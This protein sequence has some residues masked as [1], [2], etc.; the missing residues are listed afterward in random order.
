MTGEYAFLQH[1]QPIVRALLRAAWHRTDPFGQEA[2]E[3]HAG[4]IA[5]LAGLD[6][7][8]VVRGLNDV[9]D[10]LDRWALC[11]DDVQA[12]ARDECLDRSLLLTWSEWQRAECDVL[13]ADARSDVERLVQSA[14]HLV[15]VS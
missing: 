5:E 10:T 14:R 9:A 12:Y 3:L 11:N 1:E 7:D 4:D 8:A 2:F 15:A 6:R 13:A